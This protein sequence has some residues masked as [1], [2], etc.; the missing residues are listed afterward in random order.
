[1]KKPKEKTYWIIISPYGVTDLPKLYLSES[2]AMTMLRVIRGKS[3]E[4][5]KEE[6]WKIVKVKLVEVSGNG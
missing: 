1:M 3:Q 6:G 2:H 5:I 4:K